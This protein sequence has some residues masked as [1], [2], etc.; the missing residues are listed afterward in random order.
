[1]NYGTYLILSACL[2]SEPDLCKD[3]QLPLSSEVV[4]PYMCMMQGQ[5][6]M[7]RWKKSNPAWKI[8]KWKCGSNRKW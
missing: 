8:T 6:T 7:A 2:V 3:T 1:M 5:I 4:T